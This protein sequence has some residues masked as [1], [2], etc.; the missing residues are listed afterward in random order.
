[1]KQ[2]LEG[3]SAPRKRVHAGELEGYVMGCVC[4][5]SENHTSEEHFARVRQGIAAA[6]AQGIFK[7]GGRRSALSKQRSAEPDISKWCG[8]LLAYGRGCEVECNLKRG[9][10]GKCEHVV[11][12]GT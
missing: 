1:M 11:P 7:T 4:C 3:L 5:K 6:K 10:S 8:T 2:I 12:R 9:H